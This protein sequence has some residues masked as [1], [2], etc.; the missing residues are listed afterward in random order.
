MSCLDWIGVHSKTH[1]YTH[2][3]THIYTH[4]HIHRHTDTETATYTATHARARA[5]AYTHIYRHHHCA[6]ILFRV[7]AKISASHLPILRYP[8]PVGYMQC[9]SVISYPADVPC[10]GPL[11]SSDLFNYVCDLYIFSYPDV[12]F[13]VQECDV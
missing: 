11:L 1:T 6:A 10:P 3:N 9:P 8:L 5:H 7:W 13:S 12:C 2:T 4:I